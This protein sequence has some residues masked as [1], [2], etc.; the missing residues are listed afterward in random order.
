MRFREPVTPKRSD[1]GHASILRRDEG[2]LDRRLERG[3]KRP[4]VALGARRTDTEPGSTV[5]SLL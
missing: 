4:E 1:L 3:P 2:R 5:G